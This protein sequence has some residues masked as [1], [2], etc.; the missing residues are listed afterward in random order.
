MCFRD[1]RDTDG[2][3]RLHETRV[4]GI[5]QI[6]RKVPK[7]PRHECRAEIIGVT[8]NARL[9]D[10]VRLRDPLHLRHELQHGFQVEVGDRDQL[11]EAGGTRSLDQDAFA[12]H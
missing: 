5:S 8:V 7:G 10:L 1:V 12:G 2:D 3:Q 11:V 6:I 4:Q 9:A